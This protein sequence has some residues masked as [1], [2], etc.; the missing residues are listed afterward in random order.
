MLLDRWL[1]AEYDVLYSLDQSVAHMCR[2]GAHINE[3][4]V[5]Q[6]KKIFARKRIFERR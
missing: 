4:T 2:C 5:C 6:A 3:I 1:R